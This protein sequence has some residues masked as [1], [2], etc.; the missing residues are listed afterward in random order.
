MRRA[1]AFVVLFACLPAVAH[2]AQPRCPLP[3]DSC[4]VQ[5]DRMR[6]RPWLGV[7]IDVDSLGR[8][9]VASVIAGGP[10]ARAGVRPGDVLRTLDSLP[11]Q[12]FFAGKAGWGVRSTLPVRVLRDGRERT[13]DLPVEHIPEDLLARIVGEHMLEGH[14]AYMV[15][16]DGGV[17]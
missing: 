1:I 4:L 8:R 12:E 14:L 13:L 3:L 10:A 6:E 7:R 15:P 17:H 11:P 2:A 9:V 16:A 5:F